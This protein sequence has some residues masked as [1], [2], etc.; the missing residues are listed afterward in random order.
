MTVVPAISRRRAAADIAAQVVGRAGNVGLGVIVAVLLVRGLGDRRYG[1]WATAQAIVGVIGYLGSMGLTQVAVRRAAAEPEREA[2]WFGGLIT[3]RALLAIPTTIIAVVAELL[4]A[5]T[6]EMT[7]V[8]LVLALMAPIGVANV[9]VYAYT[10]RVRN[11][12]PVAIEILQSLIWTAAVAVL[13]ATHSPMLAYALTF[14]GTA[15]AV[16]CLRVSLGVRLV[17]PALWKGRALWPDLLT[18]GLPVAVGGLLVITYAKIDQVIVYRLAGA[19]DAG[20]Y[21]S[22][23]RMVDAAQFIPVAVMTTLLPLLSAAQERRRLQ[24]LVQV[25]ADHLVMASLPIFGF[26]LAA[27]APLVRLLYGTQFEPAARALPIL[28][29]AFVLIC[30][31][32]LEGNLVIVLGLQRRFVLYAFAALVLNVA[33]NLALVGRYG[34][35]AAAWATLATEAFVVSITLATCFRRLEMRLRFGRIAR[36]AFAAA[37]MTAIIEALRLSGVGIIGLLAASATYIPLLVT[38]GGLPS[39]ELRALL[40]RSTSGLEDEEARC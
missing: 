28:M 36:I 18:V 23:Y 12:V 14:A 24:R 15:I 11:V 10:L 5:R 31:G 38:F 13:F 4:V 17:R 19:R 29:A 34:F 20:L 8:G 40:K 3:F 30:L 7:R 27:S 6:S 26:A 16:S 9:L 1:E 2:D 33:L 21:A 37:V 22:V 39:R 25:A 35:V 32:Y